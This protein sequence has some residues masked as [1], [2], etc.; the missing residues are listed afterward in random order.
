MIEHD[1]AITSIILLMI[2]SDIAMHFRLNGT[3]KGYLSSWKKDLK[4][5]V[6]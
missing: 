6:A 2:Y 3:I 1:I 4:R 5:L